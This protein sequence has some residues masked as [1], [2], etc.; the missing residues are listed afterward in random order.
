M[1]TEELFCIMNGEKLK[2]ILN[3]FDRSLSRLIKEIKKPYKLK[4]KLKA[5]KN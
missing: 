4:N 5:E 2:K 3:K 1:N